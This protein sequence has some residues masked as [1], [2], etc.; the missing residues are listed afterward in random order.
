MAGGKNELA[1]VDLA[2]LSEYGL[3]FQFD[4]DFEE[5]KWEQNGFKKLTDEL[6]KRMSAVF[7]FI[8]ANAALDAQQ[9]ETRKALKDTFKAITKKGTHMAKYKDEADVYLGTLLDDETNQFAAQ[10]RWKKVDPQAMS[11]TPAIAANV[12]AVM[13]VVTSQYYLTE[14]N[15]GISHI[16]SKVADIKSILLDEKKARIWA[17]DQMLTQI[18]K[19]ITI[20]MNNPY[21]R[22]TIMT[23]IL[24]IKK[25]SLS[26][27]CFFNLQI[28]NRLKNLD[29]KMKSTDIETCIQEVMEYLPEFRLSIVLYEK[30]ILLEMLIAELDDPDYLSNMIDAIQE[31]RDCYLQSYE[32]CQVKL[33]EY[34]EKA[35]KINPNMWTKALKVA[36]T[37]A[38]VFMPGCNILMGLGGTAITDATEKK[39]AEDKS[40]LKGELENYLTAC[41][42]VAPIDEISRKLIEYKEITNSPLEFVKSG[43]DV[44]FRYIAQSA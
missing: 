11:N 2:E 20:I 43:D 38:L 12:F 29:P 15:N 6:A 27:I 7:Q 24:A 8:P 23:Q 1:T 28:R 37:T 35:E 5:D 30:A 39:M 13:S 40:K 31:Y 14:I 41:R 25:D 18:Y 22:Q 32:D 36:S 19:N 44:Y 10:T 33:L 16:D 34:L 4:N 3:D 17:N 42:D 9:A 26:D 21:E